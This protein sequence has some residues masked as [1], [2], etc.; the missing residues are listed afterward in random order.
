[1]ANDNKKLYRIDW[2]HTEKMFNNQT[3]DEYMYIAATSESEATSDL[4][5]TD[6]KVREATIEEIEA[7]VRGYE[8]GYDSGVVTERLSKTERGS[9][10]S[11]DDLRNI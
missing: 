8:D 3:F 2:R 11:I 5:G 9:N 4:F 7:Y 1:M 10:I 6:F